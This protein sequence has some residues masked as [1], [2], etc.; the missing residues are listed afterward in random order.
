MKI[1]FQ[2]LSK[3][4]WLTTGSQVHKLEE[5]LTNYLDVKYVVA[6]NSCTAALHLSLA[7]KGFG[8][9]DKFIIPTLTFASTIECGEYLGMEPVLVD[10]S[11]D[12]FLIDL[13]QIE[14]LVKNDQSIKAIVPMHYGGEPVN[15]EKIMEIAAKYNLFV[16]QDAAHALETEYNGIKIGKTDH[17]AAFS[18]YANKNM[19]TGGEGGAVSTN[20][21]RLAKK[22]KKLS[23]HGITKDGWNRFKK[24]GNWEYDIVEMG[25]KYNLTDYA[26]CFGLWQMNQI[27]KWQLRRDEIVKKYINGLNHIDSIYLPK[28]SKGHSKH[29]FVIRL[30]LN[31]WSISRNI[32]IEKM[33]KKGIGLAVHYKPL[34]QLSYYKNKYQFKIDNFP[35][36]NL[37]YESIISLPIYPKLSDSSLD[38]IINS[39]TELYDMY[40]K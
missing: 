20:D 30:D 19:T 12:G 10:S 22:I 7:A 5:K 18:F 27:E 34:H 4:G 24:D 39:I 36:A 1:Y 6:V 3:S 23:L 33:N 8:L 2:S 29:L 21:E 17:A 26:A 9:N 13:N 11:E 37:L 15:L 16:L 40:S 25:Y 35:M 28:V 32:F 14:D 31:K 38:H